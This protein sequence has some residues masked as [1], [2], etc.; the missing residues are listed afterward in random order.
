MKILFNVKKTLLLLGISALF[1]S[2]KPQISV[3]A[4]SE[5][6]ADL[7]FSTGFSEEISK[8]IHS[9]SGLDPQIPLFN[10]DDILVLLQNSGVTDVKASVPSPTEISTSGIFATDT[11]IFS[12]GFLAISKNSL[13]FT[14]GPDQLKNFYNSLN[15][16]AKSFL[17]LMMIPCLID[18]TMSPAEYKELLASMYG[19][20]F[21]E[22]I[23]D[24]SITIK[25]TS[26]DGKKQKKDTV[27]LGDLL[28][29]TQAKSWEVK[30]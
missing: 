10:K 8:T 22:E 18:E 21:A 26:P 5:N 29:Y 27:K 19:P 14:I 11:Q 23:V 24:G 9:I 30:W 16:D 17:D 4:L 25:L 6:S 15:E 1:I 7:S 12:T 28:T 20:A 2:C 13:S 3:K